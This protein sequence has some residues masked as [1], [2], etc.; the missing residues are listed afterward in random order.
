M[1]IIE[2]ND[3]FLEQY[4][5][6]IKLLWDDIEE[7]EIV[8]LTKQHHNDKGTIFLALNE[9]EVVGFLNTTIRVDYVVGSD[10][11]MTGYIE[12]IFV[13]ETYRKQQV[14]KALLE[15]SFNYFKSKNITEVGSDAHVDNLL[16]DTFHKK[17]GFKEVDVNR[18]YIIKL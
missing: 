5:T 3:T 1:K 18:H 7:K 16:S 11:D 12:G 14:G 10:S 17:V 8:S 2:Y 9:E 4:K 13:K 15:A 6:V